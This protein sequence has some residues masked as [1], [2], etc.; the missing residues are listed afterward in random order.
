MISQVDI[1]FENIFFDIFSFFKFDETIYIY[2]YILRNNLFLL[3]RVKIRGG[4]NKSKISRMPAEF[5]DMFM[6]AVA[7]VKPRLH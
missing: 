7:S 5:Y 1:E 2:I 4:M 3:K 6:H